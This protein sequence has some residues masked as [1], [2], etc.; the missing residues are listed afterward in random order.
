MSMMPITRL[1]DPVV[2]SHAA[3]ALMPL[4]AVRYH[5]SAYCGSVAAAPAYTFAL[6]AWLRN[7]ASAW[8]SRA[9]STVMMARLK[10]ACICADE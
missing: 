2:M 4:A 8:C 6:R 10:A 9:T 5:W 7:R 1:P 3:G